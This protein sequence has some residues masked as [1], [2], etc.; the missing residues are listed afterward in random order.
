MPPGHSS[1]WEVSEVPTA[2]TEALGLYNVTL[3]VVT[4]PQPL[5]QDQLPVGYQIV[6][7]IDTIGWVYQQQRR[8]TGGT[9][10]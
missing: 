4:E 6:A 8:G 3:G 1:V 9:L 2:L 5:H 10:Q 7:N